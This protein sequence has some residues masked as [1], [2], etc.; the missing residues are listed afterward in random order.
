MGTP[1][2]FAQTLLTGNNIDPATGRLKSQNDLN[3]LSYLRLIRMPHHYR[4]STNR[5]ELPG[6]YFEARLKDEA[7]QPIATLKF[8][9][10]DA[11]FWVRQR[12]DILAHSLASDE[13]VEPPQSEIIA[14]PAQETRKVTIWEPADT[15]GRVLKLKTVPEHLVPRD[16]PVARPSEWSLLMAKAYARYLCRA[17]GAATVEIVRHTQDA[18][19]PSVLFIEP[20]AGAFDDLVAN[21]G[22]YSK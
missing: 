10:A 14:A 21:F 13:P 1:P 15:A 3:L 18:I 6:A 5:P 4:F 11:N 9:D 8:P 19:P 16:R 22:E 20:Q 7:G 17:H 2:Q 12:Q